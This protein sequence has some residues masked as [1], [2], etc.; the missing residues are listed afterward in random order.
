MPRIPIFAILFGLLALRLPLS[1]QEQPANPASN[2]PQVKVNVLNVCTPSADEQKEIAAAL[3]RIPKQPLFSADFEVSRGRSTLT[4]LPSFMPAG[5]GSHVAGEPSVASYVRIRREFSV[6]A[7][8]SSVQYSFS[9]DG[10]NMVETLVLHVRDPKDLI[11]VSL[12]DSA[13]AVTS[14]AAMLGANSPASRVRLE[15]FG[16]PSV[17]LAR[18]SAAENGAAPDQS[19]Y[20]PLF[21]GASDVLTNYRGLLGVRAIVPEELAKISGESKTG[22]A[23]KP[24]TA[25]PANDKK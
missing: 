17:A 24:K 21:R 20:E 19:A 18:C 11:M 2:Q 7:L 15:R 8:F 23:S 6:Q 25:K 13:S 16:K 5:Q 12:E 9:N 10:Q 1:A 3:T 22:A 4:D 14:A